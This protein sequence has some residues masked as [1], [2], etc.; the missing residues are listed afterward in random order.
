MR[1]A[2]IRLSP[3]SPVSY[4]PGFVPA[5]TTLSRLRPKLLSWD[6]AQRGEES[7]QWVIRHERQPY[8]EWCW[9]ACVRNALSCFAV[10]ITTAQVAQELAALLPTG[11]GVGGRRILLGEIEP[12]W[13]R[14]GFARAQLVEA[15]LDEASL[16]AELR[17]NGPVQLDL[18][19]DGDSAPHHLVLVTGYRSTGAG[20]RYC[21]SDPMKP[22]TWEATYQEL[23]S[24]AMGRWRA[25][26]RGLEYRR[27]ALRR[28][29]FDPAGYYATFDLAPPDP[30]EGAPRQPMFPD[31]SLR[32]AGLVAP[33][34][35][36]AEL[37]SALGGYRHYMWRRR[38]QEAELSKSLWLGE[39]LP[40]VTLRGMADPR[41]PLREQ[42]IPNGCSSVVYVDGHERYYVHSELRSD[43]RWYSRWIGEK[44]ARTLAAGLRAVALAAGNDHVHVIR[45]PYR[46][47]FGVLF[48]LRLVESD[49]YLVARVRGRRR[50]LAQLIDG[51]E[52]A[53]RLA[54]S[55]PLELAEGLTE[56][57][58][59]A[60]GEAPG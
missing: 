58:A 1:L 48:L 50:P 28:F 7:F 19:P 34:S 21:V 53:R 2:A 23:G 42:W 29:V 18:V 44:W 33:K 38:G 11:D 12:L 49:R 37:S 16:E 41:V 25:T 10:E 27:G 30:L 31:S 14:V 52:L 46:S 17:T 43:G 9:A 47:G 45:L 8:A 24:Q 20:T 35:L 51:D 22:E 40:L 57:G 4:H 55:S 15:V 56:I 3:V 13:R 5:A 59:A 60:W 6:G 39:S 36:R 26:V 54:K 32:V